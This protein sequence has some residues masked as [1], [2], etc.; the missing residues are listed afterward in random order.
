MQFQS[1]TVACTV[2]GGFL[3]TPQTLAFE[4]RRLSAFAVRS[5]CLRSTISAEGRGVQYIFDH[6]RL[7][8]LHDLLLKK[9]RRIVLQRTSYQLQFWRRRINI[10]YCTNDVAHINISVNSTLTGHC[11]YS[12]SQKYI[13]CICFKALLVKRFIRVLF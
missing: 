11:T 13:I 6:G 9:Y 4:V 3:N 8:C 12:Q 7:K 1:K 2:G 10:G 5:T